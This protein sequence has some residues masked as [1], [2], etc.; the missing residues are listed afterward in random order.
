MLYA[1][2]ICCWIYIKKLFHAKYVYNL[3]IIIELKL[4]KTFGTLTLIITDMLLMCI[5]QEIANYN[6]SSLTVSEWQT[7]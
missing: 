7:I 4:K 2:K 3:R 5:S 1:D 6:L